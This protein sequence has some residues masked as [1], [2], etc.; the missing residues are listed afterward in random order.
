MNNRDNSLNLLRLFFA[1]FVLMMHTFGFINA[2]NNLPDAFNY[3][4]NLAVP[5]FFVVSGYLITASALKNDLKTFFKKRFARIYPAYFVCLLVTA[6]IFALISYTLVIGR[7]IDLLG[8]IS[9]N[10]SPLQFLI[11]NL[12]LFMI[13]PQ[14]GTTLS[15]ING[16]TWNGSAWTLIFE[17]GC[18]IAIALI[19]TILTRL[20]IKKEN[21]SKVVFIVYLSLI[22]FS[23]FY[24]RPEGIPQRNLMNLIVFAVNLFSVFLGGSII[25][26]I[27]EKIIFDWKYL[28]LSV[29]FCVLIM[30]ILPYSLAIE[31]CAIPMTYIILFI[32]VTLKSPK[33]IQENDISYG[34]YIYAW[35]V[36]TLIAIIL[37][38]YG[39]ICNVWIYTFICFI[40]TGI[41]ASLSWF[42]LEKPI[43]KKVR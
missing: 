37:A 5:C 40:V 7:G 16:N 34:V 12:P 36:Q 14:I 25:Y 13:C 43:L 31:I 10:P 24:P 38:V 20:K 21:L 8:Y 9:Q 17:F 29:I 39:I 4:L 6:L 42:L 1:S 19:L 26:L 23:L 15:V 28:I 3:L 27:K 35:P 2:K 11:Y 33:F 41:F 30:S 32:S 22:I 18:Y